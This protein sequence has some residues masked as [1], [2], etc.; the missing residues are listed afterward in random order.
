MIWKHI[1]NDNKF[2]A[3]TDISKVID[4]AKKAGYKF[5]SFNGDILFINKKGM[6][7]NTDIKASEIK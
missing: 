3:G 1:L 6:A 5:I 4:I 7:H 2:P